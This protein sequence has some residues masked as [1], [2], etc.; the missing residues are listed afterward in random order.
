ML[1]VETHLAEKLHAY[2][3]PCSTENARVRHLP[4]MALLGTVADPPL[5]GDR[6]LTAWDP[7]AWTWR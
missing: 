6:E 5:L 7:A 1:P 3:L 2:T 4:D